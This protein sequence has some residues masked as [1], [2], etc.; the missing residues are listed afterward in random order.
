MSLGSRRRLSRRQLSGL[1]RWLWDRGLGNTSLVLLD[2]LRRYRGLS[3]AGRRS[4]LVVYL[5]GGDGA[6]VELRGRVLRML[7]LLQLL[8]VLLLR[9]LLL[10]YRGLHLGGRH[11][12]LNGW[13]LGLAPGVV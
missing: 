6:V 8:E 2:V 3:W 5:R 12:V 10:H 1:R 7:H 13:R 4:R 9:V 11:G